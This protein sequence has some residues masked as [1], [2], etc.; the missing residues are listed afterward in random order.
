MFF[1]LFFIE[2]VVLA[3]GAGILM[4]GGLFAL[5]VAA[6]GTAITVAAGAGVAYALFRLVRWIRS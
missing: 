3:F 4:L 6:G 1:Y 2:L 5:A